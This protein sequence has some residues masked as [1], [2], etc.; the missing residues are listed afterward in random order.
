MVC[1]HHNPPRAADVM[2]MR[3]VEKA[4][5]QNCPLPFTAEG[6]QR[7]RSSDTGTARGN[8]MKQPPQKFKATQ[9]TR[10]CRAAVYKCHIR[11]FFSLKKLNM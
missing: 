4:Q 6:G 11:C 1:L 10:L 3:T 9:I 8:L 5:P 7:A 2:Q